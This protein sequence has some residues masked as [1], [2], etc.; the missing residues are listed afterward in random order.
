VKIIYSEIAALR[1]EIITYWPNTN[2]GLRIRQNY[3]FKK[4]NRR[5]KYIGRG[6]IIDRTEATIIGEDVIL[7]NNVL[8]A[9]SGMA[10]CFIGNN[11]SIA[12]GSYLRSANHNYKDLDRPIQEQGH[13]WKKVSF[14]GDDYG[15]VIED[16]VWI[17]AHCIIL[18]GAHIGKGSVI[19]AG[20]VVS[21]KVPP[22]SIVVG[23]P[24]RVILNREKLAQLKAENGE[25]QNG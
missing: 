10:K 11:V 15:I 2:F 5:I 7:G 9:I 24:G 14:C 22:Y 23:N 12:D 18:S 20:S 4:T 1:K 3:Y 25:S 8:L 21:S 19:S 17:G 6:V 16:D 13:T